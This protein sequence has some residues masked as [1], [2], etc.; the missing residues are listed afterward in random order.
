[1]GFSG[2]SDTLVTGRGRT[3]VGMSSVLDSSDPLDAALS[4]I[5][6]DALADWERIQGDAPDLLYHYTDVAGLIGICS[7]GS[8]WATNLRFMN[9]AKELAHS[10]KMMLE[11]LAEARDKAEFPA[12]LELIEEI[13]R[14]TKTEWVGYPDF[15]AT[16]FTAN[17][18]L[19]SQWRAYGSSGGGYAIGFDT[20][21]L[22]SPPSPHPQPDRFLNRVIYEEETQL[23]VLRATADKMLGL[24]EGVD[25]SSAE[26]TGARA[27]LFAALGEVVGFI[28]SFKDPAWAEEQE[29]RSVYVLPDGEH[30]G[31]EFRPVGGVAVPYVSLAM[32]TD[33]DGR[34]PIREIIQGPRV[35]KE[36]AVR[37]LELLMASNGYSDVTITVSS[38]PLRP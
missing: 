34:L 6:A 4:G 15:Y 16:S 5:V 18:D 35:D 22:V 12:Q 9:D 13:E 19:L 2:G 8:L 37:S 28:F 21:R 31:V 33:P 26:M 14:T 3:I 17:G 10:W 38:V 25:S 7:S 20:A 29:W 32:G 27:Q 23:R 1:M 24:F 30:D 11:I 36:T